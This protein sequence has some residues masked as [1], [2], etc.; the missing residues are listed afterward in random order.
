MEFNHALVRV[1]VYKSQFLGILNRNSTSLSASFL[2]RKE[3]VKKSDRI[4]CRIPVFLFVMVRSGISRPVKN[5]THFVHMH[6]V[7]LSRNN[8]SQVKN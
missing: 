6:E 5:F 2:L 4:L 7:K 8:G 3:K 1:C